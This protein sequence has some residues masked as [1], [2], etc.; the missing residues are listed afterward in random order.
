M[1]KIRAYNFLDNRQLKK[2]VSLVYGN[3][4][5]YVK[6][7]LPFFPLDWLYRKLP[8]T[9]K[10]MP[11]A[12]VALENKQLMGLISLKPNKGNWR[13]WKIRRLVLNENA[14]FIGRQLVD[15]V[16][17]TYGAKGVN[18]FIVNVESEQEEVLQLFAKGCGFKFCSF[19]QLW[20][21]N[22]VKALVPLDRTLKIRSF[23]NSDTKEICEI[24]NNGI[25]PQFRN[26][27]CKTP[28]E[29]KEGI[30]R[31]LDEIATYK[32]VVESE[33]NEITGCI[34]IKTADNLNYLVELNVSVADYTDF[35]QL[36]TFAS[37]QIANRSEQFNLF[38]INK[39]YKQNSISLE[40]YLSEND[41]TLKQ[42]QSVLVKDY[43][44]AISSTEKELVGAIFFTNIKGKPAFKV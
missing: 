29:Y 6:R 14:Y 8:I 34:I 31:G 44:K 21:M 28:N 23:K 22:T 27:L 36:I 39:K 25:Y 1:A 42:T 33:K 19:E 40:K 2:M 32:Y 3:A 24:Y 43:F 30:F 37:T 12:Y 16:I 5:I 13:K 4:R 7:S 35:A 18:T 20:Q 38:V 11:E 15:Y 41:F 9:L 17:S 10:A 26:S